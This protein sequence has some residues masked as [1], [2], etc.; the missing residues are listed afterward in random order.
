LESYT[1][2]QEALSKVLAKVK[3]LGRHERVQ[4]TSAMGRV[5]ASDVSARHDSPEFSISHMDGFAVMASDLPSEKG[6][7]RLKVVGESK[8]ESIERLRIGHGEA[9]RVSTGSRIPDGADAVIPVEDTKEAAGGIVIGSKITPGAFVY[10]AGTDFRKDDVLLRKNSRIRPQ[11][12]GLLLTLG[13]YNIEA[14]RIP[15]VAIL[16]TG[17]ELYNL[18]ENVP[19]KSLNTH[20]PLFSDMIRAAACF[21]I[22]MGVVPDDMEVLSKG[23][24]DA[25]NKADLV[26]TLGGTSVGRR[27]LVPEVVKGLSPEVFYHGLRMDRGRVAGVAVIGGKPLVMLPGPVQGAMNAYFLLGIPIIDK[28][29]GG[30]KSIMMVRA[31]MSKPWKA[32]RK[33]QSFTK[34]VYVRL[35]KKG[36]NAEPLTGETESIAILTKASGFVVVPEKVT[37]LSRGDSVDVNLVPG[38][39]YAQ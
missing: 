9:V 26:L 2:V 17:T 24:S 6:R 7:V 22:D 39:S 31:K 25:L 34:V 23:I 12:V 35:D 36:L 4:T 19:G 1:G 29:R 33:F 18:G 38:F 5:A 8:P 16:A 32:R 27:D 11:D 37:G 10:K 28:L 13:L 21:P 20:G 30:G 15:T 3:P 14:V